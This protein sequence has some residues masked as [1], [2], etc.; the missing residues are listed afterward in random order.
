APEGPEQC[1]LCAQPS[2]P[3]AT[4]PGDVGASI[5]HDLGR[6]AK[7]VLSGN[8]M[9]HDRGRGSGGILCP[10]CAGYF[11]YTLPEYRGRG[12]ASGKFFTF[13]SRVMRS[14]WRPWDR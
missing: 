3:T 13:H 14:G 5:Y 8:F 4:R 6:L 12:G 1:W 11:E 2:P 7:G 9:D 10:A